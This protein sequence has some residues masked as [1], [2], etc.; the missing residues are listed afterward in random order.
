MRGPSHGQGR[1]RVRLVSVDGQDDLVAF[2]VLPNHQ[3]FGTHNRIR[4]VPRKLQAPI[5]LL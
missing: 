1:R 5:G 4:P 3:L 2:V